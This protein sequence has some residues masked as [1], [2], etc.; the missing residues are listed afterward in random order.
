M[1]CGISSLCPLNLPCHGKERNLQCQRHCRE[2]L[3]RSLRDG[4]PVVMRF[5]RYVRG[6]HCKSVRYPRSHSGHDGASVCDDKISNH[7]EKPEH[8]ASAR[9]QVLV[10]RQQFL[11]EFHGQLMDALLRL[12]DACLRSVVEDI[13][14][15]GGRSRLIECLVRLLLLP[16]N[17]L[18]FSRKHRQ[19]LRHTDAIHSEVLEQWREGRESVLVANLVQ[20]F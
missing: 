6:V 11:A 3:H 2:Q 8:G 7:I 10:D 5:E 1:E 20:T 17:H 9:H 18:Q 4:Q 14:L 13:V 16:S 12:L 15:T 19:H